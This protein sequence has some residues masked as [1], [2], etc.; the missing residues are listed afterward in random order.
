MGRQRK[1]DQ[2]LVDLYNVVTEGTEAMPARDQAAHIRNVADIAERMEIEDIE[3]LTYV[4]KALLPKPR[5]K[6][7]T[8]GK[9]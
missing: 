3:S 5:G 9:E 6:R 2:V 4:L 7:A 8:K 1:R